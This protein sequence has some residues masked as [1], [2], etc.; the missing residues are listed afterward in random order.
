MLNVGVCRLSVGVYYVIGSD[1]LNNLIL[2]LL[3]VLLQM[4]QVKFNV[5]LCWLVC[6]IL[7]MGGWKVIGILFDIFR[8]VFIIVLYL[9]NWDG[10]WGMVVKIVFGMKVKVLGKV[11]LFW[12]LLGLLLYWLG[13]ILF[14]CS[15]LQGMVGQVVDLLCNNEKMWFV[16]IFEGICKVVK[17]WKVG[18]LKIVWMV[19][20]L[21][22]IVYFYYLEKII[23][24]GLLFILSGDDVVDMVVICEFYWFWIGKIRGMV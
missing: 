4:L 24:I 16:I 5:F 6:C 14:D 18:F 7:C 20:V 1:C 3:V 12:W 22:L 17:D 9:F 13:V 10:L 21:I 15:L 11:L 19:D 8:L 23:G 2:L